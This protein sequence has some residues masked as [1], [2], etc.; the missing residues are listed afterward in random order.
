MAKSI[1]MR[2]AEVEEFLGVSRTEAY[3]II[4]RLNEELKAG[5]YMVIAGRINRRYLEQKL[6]GYVDEPVTV[7]EKAQEEQENGSI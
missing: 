7:E 5:G 3:R 6:Y 1:F 2:A 4:K